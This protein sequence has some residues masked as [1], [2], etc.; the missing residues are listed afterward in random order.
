MSR[1]ARRQQ[2]PR[3]VDLLTVGENGDPEILRVTL[4]RITNAQAAE[5]GL[6]RL[7]VMAEADRQ[8]P[9]HTPSVVRRAEQI[10]AQLAG[11]RSDLGA[12][13]AEA[14][15]A[16]RQHI[17]ATDARLVS[18]GIEGATHPDRQEEVLSAY[19]DGSHPD[20]LIRLLLAERRLVRE[21]AAAEVQVAQHEVQRLASMARQVGTA[22]TRAGAEQ[23]AAIVCA[24]VTH[25]QTLVPVEG[26][27]ALDPGVPE[28]WRPHPDEPAP[29]PVQLVLEGPADEESTPAR[30]PLTIFS[31]SEISTL[32]E[33]AYLHAVGGEEGRAALQR[34]RQRSQADGRHV[35]DVPRQG[36]HRG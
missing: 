15:A 13:A 7:L 4:R 12:Y 30:W 19:A 9:A 14:I 6:H 8:R 16:A 17:E 21:S 24:A 18:E 34:F 35:A 10:L 32:A 3:T 1:F 27:E 36:D 23:R 25:L 29:L 20:G 2:A 5:H 22:G 28:H 11:V 31:S 33:A 26:I